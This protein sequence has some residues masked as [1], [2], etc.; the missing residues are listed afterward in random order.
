MTDDYCICMPSAHAH[1]GIITVFMYY[2]CRFGLDT[3]YPITLDNV[4]CYTSNYL[5]ILQCGYSTIISS[6]CVHGSDDV[7]V[8]CC[9]LL[10]DNFLNCKKIKVTCKHIRVHLSVNLFGLWKKS[11]CQWQI[12]PQANPCWHYIGYIICIDY[13]QTSPSNHYIDSFNVAHQYMS[14]Y[15]C[16]HW[17]LVEQHVHQAIFGPVHKL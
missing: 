15:C 7:S 1:W 11:V 12:W 3:E 2:N 14:W 6:S 10:T 8:T 16:L 5:T 4:K 17:N 9:E 13:H